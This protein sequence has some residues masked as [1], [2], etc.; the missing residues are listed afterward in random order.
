M[1]GV[2]LALSLLYARQRGRGNPDDV[3]Q[4]VALLFLLRCVLD[5]LTFS[6][7]HV[8][9]LIASLIPFEALRRPVPVLSAVT[10]GA[11]LLM[12]EV[13]VPL[14]EPVLTNVA[15]LAWTI[16]LAGV[17]A[18]S[19]SAPRRHEAPSWTPRARLSGA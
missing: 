19:L 8:P 14:G 3:L 1:I 18:L 10:I 2:A 13:V 12:N 6:Y 4:L 17:M 11:L 16:P 15:Y 7:H 9:F 5:L